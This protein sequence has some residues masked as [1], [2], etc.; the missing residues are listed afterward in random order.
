MKRLSF[1]IVLTLERVRALRKDERHLATLKDVARLAG[2]SVSTV[3]HVI[4]GRDDIPE[5][6]AERVR[7]AMAQLDYRPN[8]LARALMMDRSERI[9]LVVY[10]PR[11]FLNQVHGSLLS[12][13]ADAINQTNYCI[14]LFVQSDVDISLTAEWR[15]RRL[16]GII[17]LPMPLS[18]A[19]IS[20][21]DRTEIPV[22]VIDGWWESES[23]RFITSENY[24][25]GLL[26]ARHLIERGHTK[27]A[28]LGAVP[29]DF[30]NR[31]RLNGFKEAAKRASIELNEKWI[32]EGDWTY[33]TAYKNAKA[34]FE[35][36]SYPTGIFAPGDILALGVYAAATECGIKIGE[37]IAV[38]GY[39]DSSVATQIRPT[40]SSVRQ[41][42][43]EIGKASVD[44][45][46]R[47][48]EG[49]DVASMEFPV[50]LIIRDSSGGAA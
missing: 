40:L 15:A 13:I 1:P 21:I 27:L 38:V 14:D 8:R 10:G 9:G 3:S 49:E 44:M 43:H 37:D 36:G 39:D 20:A 28:Y 19:T 12:G 29:R 5:R 25:G 4:N 41:N 32:V 6:T 17:V 31:E 33:D 16:D 2:V 46:F 50:D 18:E 47:M 11:W 45:L 42:T 30:T 23:V 48:I 34:W 22:V 7:K 26:A 35:T 24:T